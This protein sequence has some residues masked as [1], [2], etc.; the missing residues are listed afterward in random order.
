[1]SFLVGYIQELVSLVG[2]FSPFLLLGFFFAGIL[3][4]IFP[5]GMIYKFMGKSSFLSS[6]N[7]SLFGI[8]LPLCSCGV[9][10][11][12]VSLNRNG[13]SKGAS[14]SFLISTPQTGV[15]SIMVT[16]SLIG[17]PFAFMRMI[18]AF[19]T[20]VVGGVLTTFFD[21]NKTEN[22]PEKI[23][24]EEEFRESSGNIIYRIFHYAFVVFL[25][26]IAKWLV[27]GIL[28]AAFISAVLPENFFEIYIGNDYLSMLIILVASVPMYVCATSSVPIAAALMMKGLSPGAAI[29]FLMAGPA[30]NA[31]TLTVIGRTLG[32]KTLFI[33]LFS[34]VFGAFFFGTVVNEFLP[35]EL[36]VLPE[37]IMNAGG[38]EHNGILPLWIKNASSLILMVL[39]L[40]AWFQK[41]FASNKICAS[42]GIKSS[43]CDLKKEEKIMHKR[44]AVK[45]MTCNHCKNSVEN[46]L[47]SME[48]VDSALVDLSSD[49]V[50]I[51]GS[52][53]D[54]TAV[55]N[56]VNSLGYK[57]SG[58]IDSSE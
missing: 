43:E 17:L 11:T 49:S 36:F 28:I 9:I 15:D 50:E 52:E 58:K 4:V 32:K 44:F 14:V 41:Y 47:E 51:T 23:S 30:T 12:G 8:P 39:I 22:N 38:H 16:W 21:D 25:Q 34:I 55:E 29:V 1:M 3:H 26:D 45:G 27:V 33:Y 13:A 42:C 6:L 5:T 20:G 24:R 19:V 18:I 40:N 31:A 46:A 56:K 53:I 54:E 48:G 10:P 35:G 7:A 57:Y 2:E 37:T